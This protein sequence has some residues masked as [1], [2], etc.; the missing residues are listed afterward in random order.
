MPG[1]V[2][3]QT[4]LEQYVGRRST[5]EVL[6]GTGGEVVANLAEQYPELRRHLMAADGHLR[7]FVNLYVND[8]DVRGLQRD[9]TPLR[10]TDVITIIPSIAGG[11]HP[12]F[13]GSEA[14]GAAPDA[15]A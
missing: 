6:G 3:I 1:K 12:P 9:A 8:E 11:I 7:S 4:P 13:G 15:A 10:E 5:V 14:Q 2:L